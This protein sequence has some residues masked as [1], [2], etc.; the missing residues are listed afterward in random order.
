MFANSFLLEET[1]FQKDDKTILKALGPLKMYE[2]P[3][4]LAAVATTIVEITNI[5]V[6]LITGCQVQVNLPYC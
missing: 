4:R 2:L 6:T 5:S 1:L 3:L